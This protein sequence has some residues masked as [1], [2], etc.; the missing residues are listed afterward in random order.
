MSSAALIN[1]DPP[2]AAE[3]AVAPGVAPT[4]LAFLDGVRGLA[5]LCVFAAHV[6]FVPILAIAHQAVATFIVLSGFCLAIPAA[7][8]DG[9]ELPGGF[10]NYVRRRAWRILPP[11][12]A[13]LALSLLLTAIL[14]AL[15][16][17]QGAW[18]KLAGPAFDPAVIVTHVLMA[19]NFRPEWIDKINPPFWSVAIEWQIYFFFPLLLLPVWRRFG[20]IAA[21]I[22]GTVIGLAPHLLLAG[23][24]YSL[25]WSFPWFLGLF[26]MGM[27]GAAAVFSSNQSRGL[28]A[29]N[30]F[31][32]LI[33]IGA[34]AALVALVVFTDWHG[35]KHVP[36]DLLS[37]IGVTAAIVYAARRVTGCSAAKP[38]P[39]AIR[40]LESRAMV[41]V[42]AVS[43]SLYLMHAPILAAFSYYFKQLAAGEGARAALMWGIAAPLAFGFCVL[44]HMLFERPFLRTRARRQTTSSPAQRPTSA[45]ASTRADTRWLQLDVLRGIA[46]LMVIFHHTTAEWRNVGV[47]GPVAYVFR[48]GGWSGVDLFFVLSGFLIGGLLFR[49]IRRD[50][51]LHVGRFI[52]RRGFKIWPAYFVLVAYAF[53]KLMHHGSSAYDAFL[54]IRPNLLHCQNYVWHTIGH[55]WSLAVEEHFYLALPLVLWVSLRLFGFHKRDVRSVPFIA[56]TLAIFCLALRCY[57]ILVRNDYSN[58]TFPTEV[59]IDSLFFG[60]L[61][62]YIFWFKPNVMNRIRAIRPWLFVIGLAL[63]SPCL[64]TSDTFRHT[65]G[66]TLLYLGYGSILIALM[67]IEPGSSPIWRVVASHPGRALA[68]VGTFSYSI[69]LWH[70]DLASWPVH[71][72]F[73]SRIGP[74]QGAGMYCALMATYASVAVVVGIIMSLLVERPSLWVRDRFFP[75]RKRTVEVAHKETVLEPQPVAAAVV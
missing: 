34:A 45:P 51:S 14:P 60:V 10:W 19:Y 72:L 35:R 59:R 54:Q 39:L 57:R 15:R 70:I 61:L 3:R 24:R 49:E 23:T 58:P 67:S 25:T 56:I 29:L 50:G 46:V 55:T 33:A 7:K 26:A 41:F 18:G 73:L 31:S 66:Y 21:A 38:R 9:S 12:Y 28:R 13:A 37:G 42:G 30:R 48:W 44:F 2:E 5:A 17:P 52:I 64:Y 32:G 68:F 6:Y 16:D 1:L 4:H 20:A 40:F 75:A 36:F 11:Y 71:H 43:Y 63:I 69:Y 65:I 27:C 8:V 22:T 47:M 53:V 62:S 74:I